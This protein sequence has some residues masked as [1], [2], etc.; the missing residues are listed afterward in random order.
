MPINTA[1]EELVNTIPKNHYFDSHLIIQMLIERNSD[2][3][4]TSV[5]KYITSGDITT[6]AHSQLGKEIQKLCKDHI[7][8][9]IDDKAFS[10]NIRHKLSE[11]TLYKKL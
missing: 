5:A 3:Y 8:E 4:I 2:E 6:I 11:C 10:F 7:I 1:I 9:Q